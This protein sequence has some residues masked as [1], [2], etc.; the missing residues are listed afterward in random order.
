VSNALLQLFPLVLEHDLVSV[1]PLRLLE[2]VALDGALNALDLGGVLVFLYVVIVD[3][4]LN[5]Y[6]QFSPL[7]LKALAY[8]NF[9]CILAVHHF[10]PLDIL[11]LEEAVELVNGLLVLHHLVANVYYFFLVVLVRVVLVHVLCRLHLCFQGFK[12]GRR[13][14]ALR[15]GFLQP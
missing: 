4:L 14:A 11:F 10:E 1:V 3:V 9:E 12:A 5:H 7:T 2:R 8:P 6:H 15:L 13:D